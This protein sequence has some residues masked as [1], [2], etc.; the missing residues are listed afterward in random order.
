MVAER[1]GTRDIDVG[2]GWYR[3]RAFDAHRRKEQIVLDLRRWFDA[4]VAEVQREL[5]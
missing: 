5:R 1:E 3:F 4:A 2:P